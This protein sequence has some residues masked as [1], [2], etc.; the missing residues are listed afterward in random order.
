MAKKIL[1]NRKTGKEVEASDPDI[2][3]EKFPRQFSVKPATELNKDVAKAE[4]S[5]LKN[6]PTLESNLSEKKDIKELE[7]L[8]KEEKAGKGRTGAIESIEKR[9]AFLKDQNTNTEEKSP[10]A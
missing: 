6:I 1:I 2:V 9:I 5:I 10:K 8:L 4:S 3:L 7:A